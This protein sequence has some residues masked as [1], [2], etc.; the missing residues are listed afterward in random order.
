[1]ARTP[2]DDGKY[3]ETAG[4]WEFAAYALREHRIALVNDLNRLS[5]PPSPAMSIF[6]DEFIEDR[7]EPGETIAFAKVCYGLL[8]AAV[9]R[10]RSSPSS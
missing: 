7:M 5:G 9:A 3:L 10:R 1:M 2:H 4:D 8:A 6:Q